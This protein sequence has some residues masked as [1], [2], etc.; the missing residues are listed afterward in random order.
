M[1]VT[2]ITHFICW[3]GLLTV[4]P[5]PVLAEPL[6]LLEL[7]TSQSCYSC[8]PAERLFAR[9]Y[10][11][12]PGLLAVEMH[13]DYW[14]DL[15]YGLAGSWE[16]P[17]SDPA[18]TRRQQRYASSLGQRSVYTPQAVVQ[19]ASG[20]SGT[21]ESRIDSQLQQLAAGDFSFGWQV[22]FVGAPE[23]GWQARII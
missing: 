20:M 5:R 18:F 10:A 19:G 6:L 12:R 22:E 13:V 7:F 1:P 9:K 21:A 4:L 3:V 16:D 17:F 2:R 8:P 14:D 23:S 11:D 15:I